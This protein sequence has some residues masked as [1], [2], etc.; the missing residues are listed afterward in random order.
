MGF[1]KK[2]GNTAR[3]ARFVGLGVSAA[4]ALTVFG[5]GPSLANAAEAVATDNDV[6]PVVEQQGG[7]SEVAAAEQVAP[8]TPVVKV[9][10][11][12][13][14][15]AS[16]VPAVSPNAGTTNGSIASRGD[17]AQASS[18][19]SIKQDVQGTTVVPESQAP[20]SSQKTAENAGQQAAAEES[21]AGTQENKEAE[22]SRT[23][24]GDSAKANANAGTATDG[25]PEAKVDAADSE[26]V[27]K[28]DDSQASST[29]APDTGS[30][31]E[32]VTEPTAENAQAV[33]TPQQAVTTDVAAPE[34]SAAEVVSTASSD[35]TVQA[36]QITYMN[37]YRLY[38]PWTGEHLYT[39]SLDEAK[40]NTT[41][42]WRWENVGW[43]AP[44]SG[45]P[46]YR[47]YNPYSGDH[48]YTESDSE[49]D[50]LASIGWRYEGIGWYSDTESDAV[51]VWR[52]FNPYATIG[53][54][55]YTTSTAE[56][57]NL[58]SIGWRNENVGWYAANHATIDLGQG[59]W[60]VTSSWGS[61]QRYWIGSDGVL[62]YN[63]RIDPS[64]NSVDNGAGYA[65]YAT[66]NYGGAV[67]RGAWANSNGYV[68]IADND[69]R[70]IEYND[71]TF[72]VLNLNMGDGNQSYYFDASGSGKSGFFDA[73]GNRYYAVP[74]KGYILTNQTSVNIDG[75]YYDIDA[76]GVVSAVQV[77]PLI[78]QALNY[79][80]LVTRQYGMWRDLFI[81][82]SHNTH[83]L[84]MWQGS[85]GNLNYLWSCSCAMGKPSTPTQY[86]YNYLNDPQ[87]DFQ[88]AKYAVKYA[89]HTGGLGWHI[90]STLLSESPE[91]QLGKD[92]SN[93]CIRIPIDKAKWIYDKVVGGYG[94][95]GWGTGINLY[96]Y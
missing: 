90:H 38:N 37:M 67:V 14:P 15:Q 27:P 54:H 49:R 66:T 32:E 95:W 2:P 39:S 75:S 1:E 86:G 10:A 42:G 93:G 60:I 82:V 23:N 83:T 17:G 22:D 4:V 44:D 8:A 64:T 25:I 48:H 94:G 7:T 57:D 78:Q 88:G 11:G 24:G 80:N 40:N 96:V 12:A 47:L 76:S 35:V 87:V 61:L 26:T 69:G 43:V 92:V 74:Q 46:V 59:F 58:V 55:N 30:V 6:A 65:A 19:T 71:G 9:S 63:R 51:A 84:Y 52:Q 28:K 20:A 50:Y 70:L 79:A 18:A 33:E 68:Y 36:A 89:G 77:T 72:H 16:V 29:D 85:A 91:S 34:A 45:T 56:R 31:A 5:A 41:I 81:T 73:N 13:V 62:A 3:G 21:N 53:T